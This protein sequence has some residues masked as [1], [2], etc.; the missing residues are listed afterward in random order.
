M[1]NDKE[2]EMCQE[3]GCSPDTTRK[4][5]DVRRKVLEDNDVWAERNREMLRGYG[6]LGINLMSSP[7]SGKTTLIERTIDAL[8]GRCRIGVIEGDL[9][10]DRDARRIRQRGVPVR[11]ITTGQ[12]CHL[13]AFML[14]E[15]MHNLPLDRIDL[16]FV[17]NVGN[18]V[19]PAAYDLGTGMNVVLLSTTEGDDKP[20][21][22][23]LVFRRSELM[24]ITKSDLLQG[25][26]FDPR[27]A[28]QEARAVNPLI[29]VIVL[30][31]RTG[32]G[33][34]E[35]IEYIERGAKS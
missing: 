1:V 18:L 24:V 23:P 15:A 5:L 8:R 26:D 30:S 14:H 29:Q 11:Q 20:A 4:L 17:E 2:E 12:A 9:E 34:G 6:V 31:S 33:I 32:E 16:L 10:T 22:Y 25:V 28:V 35:W 13:D 3:C 21:K 7:G 19:C 27:L